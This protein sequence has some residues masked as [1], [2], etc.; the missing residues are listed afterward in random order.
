MY[1]LVCLCI[2][3]AVR[4]GF[5]PPSA[6]GLEIAVECIAASTRNSAPSSKSFQRGHKLSSEQKMNF[7]HEF[8]IPLWKAYVAGWILKYTI[9]AEKLSWKRGR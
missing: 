6:A 9:G 3:K 5:R 7:W 4:E 1:Y 2:L 8:N